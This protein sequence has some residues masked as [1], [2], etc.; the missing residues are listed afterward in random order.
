[1]QFSGE[2]WL[3]KKYE[4]LSQTYIFALSLRCFSVIFI[5]V[6]VVGIMVYVVTL[7][8]FVVSIK[9]KDVF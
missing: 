5:P 8:V 2:N 3:R 4:L 7:V 6:G 1:M 9:Y